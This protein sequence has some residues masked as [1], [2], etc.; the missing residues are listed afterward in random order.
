MMSVHTVTAGGIGCFVFHATSYTNAH[1]QALARQKCLNGTTW[2]PATFG[3]R[4]NGLS[5]RDGHRFRVLA[6]G[7]IEEL[8]L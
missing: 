7:G 3:V 1:Q 4:D 6:T 2:S 8:P 5:C